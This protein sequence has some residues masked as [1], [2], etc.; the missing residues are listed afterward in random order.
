MGSILVI[1]M[2]FRLLINYRVPAYRIAPDINSPSL[3]FAYEQTFFAWEIMVL[4]YTRLVQ[5][6]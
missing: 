3:M 6:Q 4:L 2:K 1:S 5:M